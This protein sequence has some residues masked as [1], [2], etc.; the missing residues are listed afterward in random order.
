MIPSHA[1]LCTLTAPP[2]PTHLPGVAITRAPLD[3]VT[4]SI[5]P[6]PA[7]MDRNVGRVENRRDMVCVCSVS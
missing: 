4:C 5:S 3:S 2:R 1:S 7:L 6:G